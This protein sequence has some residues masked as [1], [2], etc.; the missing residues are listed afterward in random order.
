[1]LSSVCLLSSK[2]FFFGSFLNLAV[3]ISRFR[4]AFL[5]EFHFIAAIWKMVCGEKKRSGV[6][7][8]ETDLIYSLNDF[9]I[10]CITLDSAAKIFYIT[11]NV[12]VQIH[13]KLNLNL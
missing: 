11:S 5:S 2:F 8:F 3:L 9:I 13:Q 6:T 7:N 12:C 1:M 10:C 4:I